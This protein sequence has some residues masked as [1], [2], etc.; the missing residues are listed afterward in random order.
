M[1]WINHLLNVF[2][3]VILVVAGFVLLLVFAYLTSK[4]ER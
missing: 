4:D 3:P 1:A 2:W